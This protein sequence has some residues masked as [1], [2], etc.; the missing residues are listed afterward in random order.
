M[1]SHDGEAVPSHSI[2]AISGN[3]NRKM[4]RSEWFGDLGRKFRRQ[5][6]AARAI[7]EQGLQ[8]GL[9]DFQ[10][11]SAECGVGDIWRIDFHGCLWILMEFLN[12]MFKVVQ[13]AACM[14]DMFCIYFAQPVMIVMNLRLATALWNSWKIW[15]AGWWSEHSSQ[16]CFS[17]SCCSTRCEQRI[18]EKRERERSPWQCPIFMPKC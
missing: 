16:Y 11:R 6:V 15:N 5:L 1:C 17:C 12:L 10:A 9:Q 18:A 13:H 8:R 3:G 4:N 14:F 7:R 2:V